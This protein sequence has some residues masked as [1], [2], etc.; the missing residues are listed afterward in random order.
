[1]TYPSSR[2]TCPIPFAPS[3]SSSLSTA[4]IAGDKTIIPATPHGLL[5]MFKRFFSIFGGGHETAIFI[6]FHDQKISTTALI[7][8]ETS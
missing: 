2:K 7:R 3:S 5:E 8:I 1:V 4:V 6:R